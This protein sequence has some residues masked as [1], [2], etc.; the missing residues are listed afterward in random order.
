[1][2]TGEPG[3]YSRHAN[4]SPQAWDEQIAGYDRVGADGESLLEAGKF[5]FD[6]KARASNPKLFS[7]IGLGD[8]PSRAEVYDA[9]ARYCATGEPTPLKTLIAAVE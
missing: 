9:V 4:V 5:A 3:V 2:R 6:Y 1:M 7:L 8:N